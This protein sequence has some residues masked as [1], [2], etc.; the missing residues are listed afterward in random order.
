M[1]ELMIQCK[2]CV[3]YCPRVPEHQLSVRFVY[4]NRPEKLENGATGL[5][6]AVRGGH[7][8]AVDFLLS[9]RAN[10]GLSSDIGDSPLQA[11]ARL[12]DASLFANILDHSDDVSV[13]SYE[14]RYN[15]DRASGTSL[16]MVCDHQNPLLCLCENIAAKKFVAS[17]RTTLIKATRTD[18][19]SIFK[20]AISHHPKPA[21]RTPSIPAQRHGAQDSD[22]LRHQK[23]PS[24]TDRER[25]QLLG[26]LADKIEPFMNTLANNGLEV[27]VGLNLGLDYP[28]VAPLRGWVAN[29]NGSL[30]DLLVEGSSLGAFGPR[31]RSRVWKTILGLLGPPITDTVQTTGPSQAEKFDKARLE[32]Y[33][34]LCQ[35]FKDGYEADLRR[36]RKLQR[37]G[38][39]DSCDSVS[40]GTP[41]RADN[42]GGLS[43]TLRQ[44]AVDL[45]RARK[46]FPVERLAALQRL[47]YVFA[48]L[49]PSLGYVQGMHDIACVVYYQFH[50]ERRRGNPTAHHHSGLAPS[51]NF[52]DSPRKDYSEGS[53]HDTELS[54]AP[55]PEVHSFSSPFVLRS[56]VPDACEASTFSV[57]NEV[58]GRCQLMQ[59]LFQSKEYVDEF[60]R[61]FSTVLV[62]PRLL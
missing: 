56:A 22:L 28:N 30:R 50:S 11:A 57:L 61:I 33:E 49:H 14:H 46:D 16:I 21:E 9:H 41:V 32:R 8:A 10:V 52:T 15:A 6:L 36:C 2:P 40:I 29:K 24:P 4:S 27:A 62:R 47:L 43:M 5:L 7:H 53:L 3:C 35:Q 55:L 13:R 48:A 42:G 54:G 38:L 51:L 12:G 39:D 34:G 19:G 17:V 59:N 20:R 37:Q 26:A 44:I 25:T 58:V 1:L 23:T 45:K 18:T 31:L 60:I